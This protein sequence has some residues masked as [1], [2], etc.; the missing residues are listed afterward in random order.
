[1]NIF[2]KVMVASCALSAAISASD[3][4]SPAPTGCGFVCI[5]TSGRAVLCLYTDKGW[6]HGQMLAD[7]NTMCSGSIKQFTIG[8]QKLVLEQN[9]LYGLSVLCVFDSLKPVLRLWSGVSLMTSDNFEII[10]LL[11]SN[12]VLGR[13]GF[14]LGTDTEGI[15]TSIEH[16]FFTKVWPVILSRYFESWGA[17]TV[18][19][20]V[21]PSRSFLGSISK[22]SYC[23]EDRYP[24]GTVFGE[25]TTKFERLL[26][27][28]QR[29]PSL[30]L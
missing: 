23:E 1:V 14:L 10:P 28:P 26:I 20:I 8:S 15:G 4:Q 7:I 22:P 25:S 19:D 30:L 29:V 17:E 27:N 13:T 6:I 5:N 24:D 11:Q 2:F 9:S 12:R 21:W 18:G 3:I 16:S